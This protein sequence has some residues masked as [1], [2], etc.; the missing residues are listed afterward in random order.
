LSPP[1]LALQLRGGLPGIF[2]Q[3]TGLQYFVIPLCQ[4]S[5]RRWGSVSGINNFFS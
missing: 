3:E 1:S 4:S 5:V 2:L